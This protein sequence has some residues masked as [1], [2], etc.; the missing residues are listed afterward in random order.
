M[1]SQATITAGTKSLKITQRNIRYYKWAR[2]IMASKHLWG[3]CFGLEQG[4]YC[5]IT[6]T[7]RQPIMDDPIRAKIEKFILMHIIYIYICFRR[8]DWENLTGYHNRCQIRTGTAQRWRNNTPH[9][10]SGRILNTNDRGDCM[11]RTRV[12]YGATDI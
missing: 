3:L 5:I 9:A 4:M 1:N 7:S 8:N 11:K 10:V 6:F 12:N 2:Y